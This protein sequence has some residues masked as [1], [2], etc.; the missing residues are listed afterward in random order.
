MKLKIT[1]PF[2]WLLGLTLFSSA[3]VWGS[4][5]MSS[6][7]SSIAPSETTQTESKKS[8]PIQSG[9]SRAEPGLGSQSFD[10][11]HSLW[12][13]VLKE[14]VTIKGPES[15]VDYAGLRKNPHD[16]NAYILSLEKVSEKQFD[17][18]GKED[19]LAFLINAYNAATLKVIVNHYP[20]ASIKKIGG[21][22]STGFKEK[23]IRL[24]GVERTLDD[25]EHDL[26]GNS[27]SEPRVHFAI[28]CASR[29][30]PELLN[31]PYLGARLNQ[32]LD[33]QTVAYLRD[34]ERN[35]FVLDEHKLY[36]S[37]IFKWY[38]ADFKNVAGSVKGFVVPRLA[39]NDQEKKAIM[40][41]NIQ[42]EYID[43]DWALNDKKGSSQANA[44]FASGKS[45]VKKS[46][47]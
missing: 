25:I 35:R 43:Y 38:E 12:Y 36:L 10:H 5:T 3:T 17:S 22:F 4:G 26:I 19:Q 7:G 1:P 24:G 37:K 18:F 15:S 27:F 47:S 28:V 42:V 33:Q 44:N 20:V 29:S 8:A 14:F 45:A 32:Q 9:A 40:N 21:A 16:L 11:S 46:E 41:E 31:E 6:G 39:R 23:V 2:S 13:K 34:T 30:C